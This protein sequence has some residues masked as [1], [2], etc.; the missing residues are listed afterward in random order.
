MLLKLVHRYTLP[1][2]IYTTIEF[3]SGKMSQATGVTSKSPL[4]SAIISG[5]LSLVI[6]VSL[7]FYAHLFTTQLNILLGGYLYSWLF[8]LGLTCLSNAEMVIFGPEFQAKLIPEISLCLS[9]TVCAA[10]FVHRVCA[11]TC[12]LFSLVGL[13]FLNRI[14]TSYYSTAAVTVEGHQ[15]KS[16]KKFK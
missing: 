6:F 12:I 2:P 10:A 7:R 9:L 16:G 4:I 8:I 14:S 15:R 13:Y 3:S 1:S 5:I 11:T